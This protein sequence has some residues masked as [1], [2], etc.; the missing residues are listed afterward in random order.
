MFLSRN[1]RLI[2]ARRKFDVFKTNMLV[3]RTS[4]LISKG[5]LSDRQFQDINTLLSCLHCL[6]LTFLPRTSS[7]IILNYFQFFEKTAVK[8]NILKKKTDKNSLNTISI[9]NSY[10]PA[11]L[12][13]KILYRRLLSIRV[14]SIVFIARH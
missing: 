14:F 12:R 7:K 8:V 13:K 4:N 6:P 9:V 1:Y 10:N 2:I 11:C 3:L 5:Q